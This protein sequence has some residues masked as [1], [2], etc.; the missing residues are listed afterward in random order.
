LMGKL[1]GWVVGEISQLTA[2]CPPVRR[3]STVPSRRVRC[4]RAA[5]P[6]ARL[7]LQTP[8]P[9]Q[10]PRPLGVAAGRR[11][12]SSFGEGAAMK[13]R[14]L[15][16][17]PLILSMGNPRRHPNPAL[18]A[19]AVLCLRLSERRR[20]VA[21]SNRVMEGVVLNRTIPSGRCCLLLHESLVPC[22][23][24]FLDGEC[25]GRKVALWHQR[26]SPVLAGLLD[27]HRHCVLL[28]HPRRFGS[29]LP[30]PL[31]SGAWLSAPSPSR[32]L[33]PARSS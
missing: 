1:C 9:P 16:S 8:P 13:L 6:R 20:R 19:L 21:M 25:C 11:D 27:D 24:S 10:D 17:A 2:L 12:D 15:G 5:A 32:R 7:V 4:P 28:L 30:P 3:P 29:R 18:V 22:A 26:A 33:P 14:S 31:L 23:T